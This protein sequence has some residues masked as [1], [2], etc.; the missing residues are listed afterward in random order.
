MNETIQEKRTKEDALEALR[1]I[2]AG[3]GGTLSK[4]GRYL[5]L[6][7]DPTVKGLGIMESAKHGWII[8]SVAK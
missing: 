7:D 1:R 2:Q 5:E 4:N 3:R 6:P 8:V